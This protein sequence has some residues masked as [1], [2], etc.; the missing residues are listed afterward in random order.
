M[1][2]NEIIKSLEYCLAQGI[3]SECERCRDKIGCRDTLLRDAL[4]IIKRKNAEIE[5]L[6]KY[7]HDYYVLK[8]EARKEFWEQIKEMYGLD[9]QLTDYLLANGVIVPSC[10]VGD[11]TFLLLEKDNE[12]YDIVE[13]RCVRIT[14]TERGTIY[15]MHFDCKEIDSSIEFNS[16]DFGKTVFFS[17]EEA[18]KDLKKKCIGKSEAEYK[19]LKCPCCGAGAHPKFEDFG[20][21]FWIECDECGLQT[22]RYDSCGLDAINAWNRREG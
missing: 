10:K 17:H 18:K 1:T 6:E 16:D 21:T 7:K 11:Q 15:S 2:D 22:K 20:K 14:Q 9:E 12:E 4:D 19:L 5:E 8:S 3:T 13:S